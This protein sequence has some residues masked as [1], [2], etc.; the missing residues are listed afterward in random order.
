MLIPNSAFKKVL[1]LP[2]V[3]WSAVSETMCERVVERCQQRLQ[4]LPQ[5]T[6]IEGI[7]NL[8]GAKYLY[9]KALVDTLELL[10]SP[11]SEETRAELLLADF[12]L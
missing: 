1:E 2:N 3:D 6:E 9:E 11:V 12:L 7:K 8:S 10:G 4:E 5:V